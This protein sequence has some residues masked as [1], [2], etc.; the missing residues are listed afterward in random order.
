MTRFPSNL[1]RW[2]AGWIVLLLSSFSALADEPVTLRGLGKSVVLS[3]GVIEATLSKSSSTIT[4]IKLGR[5]EM[6]SPGK[7]V[8]YIM[9]GG[10]S[11]RQPTGAACRV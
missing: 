9:G 6:V 11:Y 10:R 5:H 1:R 8:Y 2:I 3:N 4:S 7:P